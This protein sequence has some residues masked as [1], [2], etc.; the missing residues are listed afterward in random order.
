MKKNAI[1]FVMIFD[2]KRFQYNVIWFD[3][4]FLKTKPG[5][6]IGKLPFGYKN[7]FET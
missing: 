2:N 4:D 3:P 1:F 5:R 6:E 7:D